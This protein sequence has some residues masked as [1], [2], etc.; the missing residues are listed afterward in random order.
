MGWTRRTYEK[1][2]VHGALVGKSERQGPLA[3]PTRGWENNI[4]ILVDRAEI[5]WDN[6]V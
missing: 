3:I 2:N 5:E 1:R 4:K 6:V